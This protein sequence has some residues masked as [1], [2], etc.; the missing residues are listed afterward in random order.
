MC[1]AFELF[2]QLADIVVIDAR[3]PAES[4]G[5]NLELSCPGDL[6]LKVQG[7]PQEFVYDLLVGLPAFAHLLLDLCEYVIIQSQSRPHD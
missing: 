4:S 3:P 5:A 2:E 7:S 6:A 1:R